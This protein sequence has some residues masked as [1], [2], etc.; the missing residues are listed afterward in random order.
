MHSIIKVHNL[1]VFKLC[2]FAVVPEFLCITKFI[3]VEHFFVNSA[4][5]L[6][7]K[8]LLVPH[9]ELHRL[10][11][12]FALF[13]YVCS[14]TKSRRGGGGSH[15]MIMNQ[16]KDDFLHLLGDEFSHLKLRC[17]SERFLAKLRL[18]RRR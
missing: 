13:C 16:R 7:S 4:K 3:C 17:G 11:N 6:V 12:L 8:I 14:L 2:A 15:N 18:R 9:Q 10:E 1:L 5:G